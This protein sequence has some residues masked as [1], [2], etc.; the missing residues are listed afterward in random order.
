MAFVLPVVRVMGSLPV[1]YA[2]G[3]RSALATGQIERHTTPHAMMVSW[4]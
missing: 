3:Q 1:E 4:T 2:A